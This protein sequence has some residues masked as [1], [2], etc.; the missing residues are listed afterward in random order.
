MGPWE[1]LCHVLKRPLPPVQEIAAKPGTLWIPIGERHLTP[2]GERNAQHV[3]DAC[4]VILGLDT[5]YAGSS[6]KRPLVA[7]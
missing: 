3:V 1:C 5:L 4:R 2:E 7:G 6:G